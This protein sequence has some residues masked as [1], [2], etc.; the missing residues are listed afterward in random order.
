MVIAVSLILSALGATQTPTPDASR[1]S[2]SAPA[3]VVEIDIGKLK[4]DLNRLSWSP[5]GLQLYIQTAERDAAGRIKSARHYLL[6]LDGKPPRSVDAEPP[7]SAA[8]WMWKS[9]QAAPG[10]PGFKIEPEQ[11]QERKTATSTPAGGNLARGGTDT[12]GSPGGG[13]T[14][15]GT[16]DVMS[17]AFQSQMVQIITLR[18]K[19]EVIGEFVNA[20][21]A[22]GLTWGW[23][24]TGSR[25]VA[26]ANISGRIIVM[27]DQG[28]KQEIESSR[29]ALLPAWSDDGK[30]LAYLEKSGRHR[31]V[32]RVVDVNRPE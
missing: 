6:G 4:G 9:G 24:P 21:L 20:P 3:Q 23:G 15:L 22:P 30:R 31:A 26:F 5:D 8:Y 27:D 19:G 10:A 32:L 14:G 1:L 28:R 17:A 12:G 7:W 16:G 25:L 29:S 11:R 2:V 13:A 18:L